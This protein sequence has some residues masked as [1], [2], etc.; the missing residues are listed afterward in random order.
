MLL[1]KPHIFI[2]SDVLNSLSGGDLIG[3]KIQGILDTLGL[4]LVCIFG[5]KI[6]KLA[7]KN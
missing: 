6:V 2:V 4:I 5:Y 7:Y 1:P 3:S